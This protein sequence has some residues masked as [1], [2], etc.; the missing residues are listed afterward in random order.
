MSERLSLEDIN[1]KLVL[2]RILLKDY[3]LDVNKLDR[4]GITALHM[5]G[6]EKCKMISFTELVIKYI[7]IE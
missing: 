5:D 3:S 7:E 1:R 2:A 4:D 6:W